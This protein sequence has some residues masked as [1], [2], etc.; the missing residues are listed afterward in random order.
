VARFGPSRRALV[1][2]LFA[3]LL[4]ALAGIDFEHFLLPDRIT[5]PG[6]ALGLAAQLVLPDGSFVR[7]ASP[8]RSSALGLLLVVAGAW[9]LV[10]G[11]EGM[12]LGDVKMLAM[13]GALLGVSGVLVTLLF[14]TLR[15]LG[16]RL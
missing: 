7:A 11:F 12:G 15:R 3:A 16:R 2:A 5:L 9:E 6:I 10:R 1:A 13:V 14:G 8:E 4:V